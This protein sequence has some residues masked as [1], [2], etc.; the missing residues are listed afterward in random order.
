[1]P[2]S[3]ITTAAHSTRPLQGGALGRVCRRVQTSCLSPCVQACWTPRA[4]TL[5][6][7]SNPLDPPLS[8]C[9][10]AY[11]GAFV[12]AFS[13][14][15]DAMRRQG[16]EPD[17]GGGGGGVPLELLARLIGARRSR[18]CRIWVEGGVRAELLARLMGARRVRVCVHVHQRGEREASTRE[19]ARPAACPSC[20]PTT[21]CTPMLAS[22]STRARTAFSRSAQ[23]FLANV[24]GENF[25]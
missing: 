6:P 1:M 2:S 11:R 7:R 19:T 10:E 14:E 4:Q 3:T 23:R 12:A 20:L 5:D 24:F 8:S 25:M 16:G 9:R 18:W 15:L 22:P 13:D 17:G 21:I